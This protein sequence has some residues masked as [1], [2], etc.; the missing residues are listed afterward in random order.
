MNKLLC[1][2][3]QYDIYMSSIKRSMKMERVAYTTTRT[4]EDQV[5]IRYSAITWLF[6]KL[7]PMIALDFSVGIISRMFYNRNVKRFFFHILFAICAT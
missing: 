1:Y 3:L 4:M 7:M 6:I 5:V 2:S